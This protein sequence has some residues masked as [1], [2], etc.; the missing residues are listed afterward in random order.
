MKAGTTYT[1]VYIL[2]VTLSNR[3]WQNLGATNVLFGTENPPHPY[4]KQVFRVDVSTATGELTLTQVHAPAWSHES[5][6]KITGEGGAIA[7]QLE[8]TI[9]NCAADSGRLI[10]NYQG[11]GG[12]S[13][14][15]IVVNDYAEHY[16]TTSAPADLY[17]HYKTRH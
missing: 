6:G 17:M 1:T 13:H 5:E 12:W 11:S 16:S 10:I 14:I 15:D 2:L 7:S 3:H 4:L 8:T 9:S